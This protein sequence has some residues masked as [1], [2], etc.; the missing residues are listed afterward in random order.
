MESLAVAR[1]KDAPILAASGTFKGFRPEIEHDVRKS[2]VEIDP[3]I[4]S[5]LG[6][7]LGFGGFQFQAPGK[8]YIEMLER[9]KKIEYGAKDIAAFCL[10]LGAYENEDNFS[11]NTGVFLSAL[12][13]NCRDS[14]F[15]IPTNHL[16]TWIRYIGYLNKKDIIIEGNAGRCVGFEMEGGTIT[17]KGNAAHLVGNRMK[18]GIITVN[19]NA[20]D[21]IGEDMNGGD[22]RILGDCAKLSSGIFGGR[23]FHKGILIAGK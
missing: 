2:I 8:N 15:I 11:S 3:T 20:A 7:R 18:G 1:M 13:N 17:V 6:A 14:G 10:R 21:W 16:D 23:I 4:Q 22:I 5:M 12:I 19:G 9:V